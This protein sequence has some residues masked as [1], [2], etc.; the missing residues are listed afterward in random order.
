MC[1][2][3]RITA[4]VLSSFRGCKFL[5]KDW[6]YYLCPAPFIGP[7]D[8]S[9]DLEL[10]ELFPFPAASSVAEALPFLLP[11]AGSPPFSMPLASAPLSALSALFTEELEGSV[12][13]VG[14]V[15]RGV[16]EVS[17]VV[18][19]GVVATEGVVTEPLVPP[20]SHW[21]GVVPKLDWRLSSSILL[22]SSLQPTNTVRPITTAKSNKNNL[23]IL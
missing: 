9:V 10:A 18:M 20:P 3:Q 12:G 1:C 6:Y 7:L 8:L 15:G 14:S 13:V 11:F 21:E 5:I 22:S 4:P 17:G 23:F 2:T 16:I 19:L